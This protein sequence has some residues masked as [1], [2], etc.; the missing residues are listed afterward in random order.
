ME[1]QNMSIASLNL[2]PR[3][4][5]KHSERNLKAIVGSLEK[6]GQRKPIVISSDGTVLAGNGTVLAATQLGWD[7]IDVVVAPGDWDDSML[8]AYALADN[9]TAELAEWDTAVLM[10]QLEELRIDEFDLESLG[11]ADEE[12]TKTIIPPVADPETGVLPDPPADPVTKMGDVWILGNHKVLC[13]DSTTDGAFEALMGEELAD[14]IMTDPPYGV[15]YTGGQN[16]VKREMLKNDDRDVFAESIPLGYVYS[17]PDAALYVWFAGSKGH[18]AFDAVR[19]ANYKVRA[20]LLW[21]K[22]KAH[23]GAYMSQYMPKHEPMLYCHKDGESPKWRGPNNE[24]TVWEYEQPA[25]NEW[26]PTQKPVEV[27]VRAINNSSDPGDLVLDY[28]GGSGSTLIAAAQTGRSARIIEFEPK[29]VDVICERFQ[30]LTGIIPT[31]ESTGEA[32][33]FVTTQEGK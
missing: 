19:S 17:K 20:M 1:I 21:H 32:H 2:D 6:F 11:F 27:M 15:S 25:R 29:F 9:R 18:L 10:E 22:L 7:S 12:F 28:F 5:R 24:V 14:M 16:D 13:G 8:K 31:L 3:N 26:H 33:D 30:R 4:A 23:Y